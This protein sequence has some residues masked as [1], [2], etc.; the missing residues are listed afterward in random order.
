MVI[1]IK[2]DIFESPAQ[3]LVNTV[4]TVGVMGKG[5]AKRFKNVYPEMYRE[6]Q[7]YCE[8]G[9]LE[10]GKLWIYKTPNKW[11]LN[12]PTKLHWRTPSK[13]E[14]IEQGLQKFVDTYEEK[15][16]T[17]IS[18]PQLGC[19]NGGLNW[20]EEVKPLM[21]KYLK[22]L[23]I[24]VFIHLRDDDANREHMNVSETKT[25]LRASPSSLSF[26]QVWEDI[27]DSLK[28]IDNRLRIDG[29]ELLISH[30][31]I[32][33]DARLRIVSNSK[34]VYIYKE[35]LMG[36]WINLRSIGYI[37]IHDLPDGL[38]QYGGLVLG[39]MNTLEYIQP[40][41]IS[42]GYIFEENGLNKKFEEGIVIN[43]N[44]LPMLDFAEGGEITSYGERDE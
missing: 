35:E 5:I 38:D 26:N 36:L 40:V 42:K 19:G 4:N 7:Y 14:Y 15:G 2:Q 12:F 22:N 18:F 33:G 43:N 3:V 32:K 39:L 27:L 17:S 41:K 6:Y 1:Y 44:K 37:F 10:I 30:E 9:F 16:I 34:C 8:K 20:E 11:I 13:I 29:E 31:N 28:V 23:S 21:E 25:W 24:D